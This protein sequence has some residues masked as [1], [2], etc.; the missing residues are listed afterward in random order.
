MRIYNL[1]GYALILINCLLAAVLAPPEWSLWLGA[2]VGFAYLALVWFWGGVYLAVV[3]HM[4]IA[5]RALDFN[6]TF[7]KLLTII[8]NTSGIYVNPSS[9]VDRHRHHHIYSD[10]PGDPNKLSEDGFWKTLYLSFFPYKCKSSLARDEIFKSRTFRLVSNTY[11]AAFAQL[12][13]FGLLWLLVRDWKYALLLWLGVRI[14]ALYANM[15]QNYWTHDRRFGSRRYEDDDN[16]MNIGDWLP[17]TLTFSACL[18]NNHHHH[19][20]FLRLSHDDSEYDFGFIIVRIIKRMGL[21]EA[22]AAGLRRPKDVP[23]QEVGF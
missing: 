15:I 6:D 5:H 14:T 21:V 7:V 12:S 20:R 3:L 2:L 22:T 17:V 4:G 23:L 8:Y 13:S 18:Q 10:R 11:F 19:P 16:A 1:V 9:W